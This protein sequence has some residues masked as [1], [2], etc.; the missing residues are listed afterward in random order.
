MSNCAASTQE[1]EKTDEC[2]TNTEEELQEIEK[3]KGETNKKDLPTSISSRSS[4]TTGSSSSSSEEAP[5]ATTEEVNS[6]PDLQPAASESVSQGNLNTSI[7]SMNS[8]RSGARSFS[9]FPPIRL[10]RSIQNSNWRENLSNNL[11]SVIQSHIYRP[12]FQPH[13]PNNRSIIAN[14]SNYRIPSSSNSSFR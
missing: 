13:N 1:E 14:L 7:T 4:L 11:T 6:D 3:H 8:N 10:T 9:G 12:V 5:I 2:E